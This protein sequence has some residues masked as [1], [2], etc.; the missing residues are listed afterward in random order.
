[1]QNK[2][3]TWEGKTFQNKQNKVS[4]ILQPKVKITWLCDCVPKW[5]IGEPETIYVQPTIDSTSC[6]YLKNF[7]FLF[8]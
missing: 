2:F 5:P 4:D 6:Q 1:M 7:L 8:N 3:H